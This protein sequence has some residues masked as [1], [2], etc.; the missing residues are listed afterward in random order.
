MKSK[1]SE[2]GKVNLST[3][4]RER[5]EGSQGSLLYNKIVFV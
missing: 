5:E 4:Q 2:K 3:T 1:K